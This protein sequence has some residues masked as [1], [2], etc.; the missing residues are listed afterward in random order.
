[1]YVLNGR[2][3]NFSGTANNVRIV[4]VR[5]GTPRAT[6]SN[7]VSRDQYRFRKG[8][9]SLF[10]PAISLPKFHTTAILVVYERVVPLLPR[11]NFFIDKQATRHDSST[12]Y[13]IGIHVMCLT[14]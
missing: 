6:G 9:D 4:R 7:T 3:I 8:V 14:L 1:M 13:L 2:R 12:F 11:R 10:P 5:S